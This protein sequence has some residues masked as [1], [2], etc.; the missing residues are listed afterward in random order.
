MEIFGNL[1]RKTAETFYM[2]V[3]FFFKF[4]NIFFIKIVKKLNKQIAA[5]VCDAKKGKVRIFCFVFHTNFFSPW[6]LFFCV[7]GDVIFCLVLHDMR[8]RH[9]T[10]LL[11]SFR[12]IC[13]SKYNFH[14]FFNNFLLFYTIFFILRLDLTFG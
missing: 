11:K 14:Y 1:H 3:N 8:H 7:G 10:N 4:W 2:I 9:T 12:F 13:V 6:E 5:S